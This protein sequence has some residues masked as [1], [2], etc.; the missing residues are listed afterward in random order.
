MAKIHEADTT[1]SHNDQTQNPCSVFTTF[2]PQIQQ[3]QNWFKWF[4]MV[5]VTLTGNDQWLSVLMQ[6]IN[7]VLLM[8][9][10]FGKGL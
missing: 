8:D 6:K 10:R 9:L 2:T 4:L 1:P 7:S 5:H 3:V